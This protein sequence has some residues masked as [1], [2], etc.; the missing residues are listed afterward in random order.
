MSQRLIP[1]LVFFA[2]MAV[3]SAV[4]VIRAWRRRR[5]E[6][7]LYDDPGR[8]GVFGGSGSGGGAAAASPRFVGTVEQIGRAVSSGKPE[9]GFREWLARA[10]YYEDAA[11][12]I[13]VGAQ[14]VLGVLALTMG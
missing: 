10:G 3:G 2:V 9:A 1:V 12:S 4:L 11:P 7:R 5:L 13:Y 6:S 8:S 14:L